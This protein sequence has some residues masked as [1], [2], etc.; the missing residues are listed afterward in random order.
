MNPLVR[1]LLRAADRTRRSVPAPKAG[2]APTSLA[3]DFDDLLL[4]TVREH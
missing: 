1:G 3:N 2:A 4:R